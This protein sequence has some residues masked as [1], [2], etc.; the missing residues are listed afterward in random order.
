MF[1]F[2]YLYLTFGPYIT[3]KIQTSKKKKEAKQKSSEGK[4]L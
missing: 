2:G 4:Q 1:L 3:F